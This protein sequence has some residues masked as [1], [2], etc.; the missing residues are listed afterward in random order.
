MAKAI[1]KANHTGVAETNLQLLADMPAHSKKPNAT[2][3]RQ[4]LELEDRATRIE[5]DP[6]VVYVQTIDELETAALAASLSNE[7]SLDVETRTKRWKTGDVVSVQLYTPSNRKAY[8]IPV[9]MQHADR[10]FTDA[11]IHQYLR[12]PLEDESLAKIGHNLKYDNQFIL[13]SFDIDVANY[14]YDTFIAARILNENEDHDL[15]SLCVR[16]LKARRWKISHSGL[17]NELWP[18]KVAIDYGTKDVIW[19]HRLWKWQLKH[20]KKP[21]Y[22]KLYSLCYDV[23]FPNV[24]VAQTMERSGIGFDV[25]Y[26]NDVVLPTLEANIAETRQKVYEAAGFEFDLADMQDKPHEIARILFDVLKIPRVDENHVDAYALT[27][28]KNA[29]FVV[30]GAILDNR[31]WTK[32]KSMFGTLPKWVYNGRIYPTMNT[33]GAKRTGRWTMDSPNLQQIPKKIGPLFRRAFVPTPG[34]VFVTLDYSQGELRVMAHLANDENMIAAFQSGMDFHAAVLCKV[35]GVEPAYYEAHKED[36]DLVEKRTLTKNI[37]FGT[38]YGMK[39]YTLS[40]RINKSKE[41]AR[42]FQ[43][44]WFGQFPGVRRYCVAQPRFAYEH[45]YVETILG[46]KRRLWPD[47]R[48]TDKK[49][50][51]TADRQSINAPIQGSVADLVKMSMNRHMEMIKANGWQ[52]VPLLNEHDEILYEVPQDWIERNG[53]TAQELKNMMENIYPLRC[54]LEVSMETLTR[55]GDKTVLD[56][57]D[58]QEDLDLAEAI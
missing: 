31:R 15:E 32:V 40:I 11:E 14:H 13:K 44:Q 8:Y 30:A 20:L 28:L 35:F 18:I 47:A 54:P 16:Y 43:Q 10:N 46:R 41:E 24:N 5:L 25:P 36:V 45:G 33:V 52:Y 2:V 26:F 7:I 58:V 3:R 1:R 39:E 38:M 57:D 6:T 42:V 29:G 22:R 9:R 53:S 34:C 12:C 50:A 4:R 49:I 27:Q 55:W 19:E 51:A 23:E 21:Q 56:Y 37:N 17:P 48:S